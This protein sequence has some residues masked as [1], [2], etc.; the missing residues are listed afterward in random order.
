[1]GEK[2]IFFGAGQNIKNYIDL[3][4]H[5]GD[6]VS[7]IL[8]NSIQ[9]QKTKIDGVEI[10]SPLDF[11]DHGERILITCLAFEEVRVLL[12][13][14]GFEDREIK[15]S[16]I[17]KEKGGLYEDVTIQYDNPLIIFDLYSRVKWGG[18]EKWNYT[19]ASYLKEFDE[20]QN[21]CLLKSPNVYINED[22]KVPIISIPEKNSFSAIIDLLSEKESLTFFNSFHSTSFFALL[23]I[24]LYLKRNVK[25]ITVVHNDYADL[26]KQCQMFDPFV[27]SYLCVSK[28]IAYTLVNTYGINRGKIKCIAQP[29]Y[30]NPFFDGDKKPGRKIRIGIA[31][32]IT[33]AQKRCDLIPKLIDLLEEKQLCYE[34]QMAGDGDLLGYIR[35]YIEKKSLKS[36]VILRGKLSDMEMLEFWKNTDIYVNVSDFEGASLAMLEAMGTMCVPVLTCVSGTEDYIEHGKSGFIHN[37]EDLDGICDSIAFLSDNHDIMKCM[38][39]EAQRSVVNKCEK[40]KICETIMKVIN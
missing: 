14:L 2:Y 7:V 10:Q 9:K 22:E 6:D 1:M 24:K 23:Y 12:R 33:K 35:E 28:K 5:M 4:R 40:Q 16:E 30:V 37:L 13:R 11:E 29:I 18:A 38:G 19:V 21:I 27:D 15:I 17:L 25:I 3:I 8:D 34:L 39:I 20:N 32:R 26:Y 31:S 36:K